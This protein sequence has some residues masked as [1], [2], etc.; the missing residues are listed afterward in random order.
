[1]LIFFVQFRYLVPNSS[2]KLQCFLDIC[3]KN[4]NFAE[5][6]CIFMLFFMKKGENDTSNVHFIVKNVLIAAAIVVVGLIV[7]IIFLRHYTQ[8]GKEVVVPELTGL[9]T[10]EAVIVLAHEQLTLQIIDSTFSR[11]VPLGTILEQTPP[12]NTHAKPGRIIYAVINASTRKQVML[13]ELHDVSFRQA[14]NTLR[15]LGL[16]IGE[17]RYEPSQYRDLVLAIMRGEESLECGVKIEEGSTIDL[18]IGQG[19]GTEM[20]IVPDLRGMSLKEARS[21]L[22]HER[23]C[24]G[25]HTYDIDPT[26]ETESQYIIYSQKPLSGSNALEG[27]GI[28][29][30]LSTDIEKTVTADVQTSEEDFF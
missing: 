28:E 6:F 12:A 14:E 11:Q 29:V 24:L 21:L 16:V 4:R 25:S 22:L 10:E 1:M 9:Y 7:L 26:E 8:H 3:K 30:W 13:P 19:Q 27:S 18:V 15:Q 17:V 20:V 5:N 23:L 2:A